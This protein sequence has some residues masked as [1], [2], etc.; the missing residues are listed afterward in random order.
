MARL[1]YHPQAAARAAGEAWIALDRRNRDPRSIEQVKPRKLKK[2]RGKTFAFRLEGAAST[3]ESVIAKLTSEST[4]RLEHHIYNQLLSE[5]GAPAPTCYGIIEDEPTGRCWLFTEELRGPHPER[6]DPSHLASIGA[7]LGVVEQGAHAL[8]SSL[9]LP[10]RRVDYVKSELSAAHARIVSATS[11][12]ELSADTLETLE[13]LGGACETLLASW[14]RVDGAASTWPRTIV[15]GDL[16]PKNIRLGERSSDVVPYAF[17]WEHAGWGN[18]AVDLAGVVGGA[19]GSLSDSGAAF[20][21]SYAKFASVFWPGVTTSEARRCLEYGRLLRLVLSITWATSSLKPS[22]EKAK[23]ARQLK[24]FT[25]WLEEACQSPLFDNG[26]SPT[27]SP[28][29][30]GRPKDAEVTTSTDR[31]DEKKPEGWEDVAVDLWVSMDP[32]NRRPS[33][34]Q[35]LQEEKGRSVYRLVAA[36]PDG[37]DI[38][39][40]RCRL[41]EA[42]REAFVYGDVLPRLPLPALALHGYVPE[43]R[44]SGWLF[45]DDAGSEIL[46]PG[47]AKDRRLAGWWLGTLHASG[48]KL[49]DPAADGPRFAE[50]GRAV[51]RDRGPA[52]HHGELLTALG[53]LS[54]AVRNPA[55]SVAHLE[56]LGAL[57]HC[58][59]ELA[60]DWARIERLYRESPIPETLVHGDFKEVHLCHCVTPEGPHLLAIDWNEAGWGRPAIDLAKFSGYP[61]RPSLEAYLSV[62]ESLWSDVDESS[63]RELGLIGEVFRAIAATRWAVERLTRPWIESPMSKLSYHFEW[64]ERSLTQLG[65]VK[66]DS[67]T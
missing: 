22:F 61:I 57:E 63:I 24:W 17:D 19:P 4:A 67:S 31:P 11:A 59:T 15:H 52:F 13:R 23:G 64:L 8:Q 47:Q 9:D 55:L 50:R 20:L 37:S 5:L 46:E 60:S 51:L 18:P 16:T 7:W 48:T 28:L 42:A 14:H 35:T 49:M 29:S 21:E 54:V 26:G 53:T 6:D 56:L 34:I 30:A 65:L 38:V 41:D 43:W 3:G 45:M 1:P 44:G 39:A 33:S 36:A 66:D 12:R 58:L 32:V 10:D 40:K 27:F 62:V 25:P 2:R